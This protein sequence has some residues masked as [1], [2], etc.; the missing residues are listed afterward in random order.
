[1]K[2]LPEKDF[3]S[4]VKTRLNNYSEMPDDDGWDRIA[5]ALPKAKSTSIG[6]RWAGIAL[7]FCWEHQRDTC[8]ISML[9]LAEMQ[10]R[11]SP[12]LFRKKKKIPLIKPLYQ[13]LDRK[14]DKSNQ[15]APAENSLATVD[16][17]VSEQFS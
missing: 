2:N 7:I 9:L 4:E 16:V 15:T 10:V 5:G 8:C 6:K 17:T 12:V 11:H 1:M 3:W 13:M 14:D